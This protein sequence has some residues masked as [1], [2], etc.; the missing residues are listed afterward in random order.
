MYSSSK[1]ITEERDTYYLYPK[2][3]NHV[4]WIKYFGLVLIL[5]FIGWFKTSREY[6]EVFN[7]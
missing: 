3:Y 1:Y 4:R 6:F 5:N 2:F 7:K